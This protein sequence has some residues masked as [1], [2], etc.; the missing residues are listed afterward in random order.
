MPAPTDKELRGLVLKHLY[1]QR[2]TGRRDPHPGVIM[3]DG[4]DREY[5]RICE[6]LK[7]AGLIDG[8]LIHGPVPEGGYAVIAGHVKIVAYGVDVVEDAGSSSPIPMDFSMITQHIHIT[9]STGI[10]VGNNNTLSIISALQS[11]STKI[12]QSDAPQSQKNEAKGLL[13]GLL[14]HPITV[15][16]L[17]AAAG[18]VVEALNK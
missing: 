15:A 8:E 18:G 16:L 4:S 1:D 17:G 12:E 11:L 5:F 2:K 13:E 6:Q 9:D 10:Q 7:Q 14:K 3:P